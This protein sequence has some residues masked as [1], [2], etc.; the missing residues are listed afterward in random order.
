MTVVRQY[1]DRSFHEL[2]RTGPTVPDANF[3]ESFPQKPYRIE[4]S[5]R[6]INFMVYDSR[7]ILSKRPTSRYNVC[8]TTQTGTALKMQLFN[9]KTKTKMQR[10][11]KMIET[12]PI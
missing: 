6:L 5:A 3:Y 12:N 1:F 10:L 9:Y 11:R 2:D 4:L 8:C 7:G